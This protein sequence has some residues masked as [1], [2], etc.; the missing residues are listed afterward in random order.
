MVAGLISEPVLLHRFIAEIHREPFGP[1][2]MRKPIADYL[3]G[4]QRLGRLG[5]FPIDAALTLM[6]GPTLVLGFT[7]LVGG[8]PR[9][10]VVAA[11]PDIIRTL[12]SGIAPKAEGSRRARR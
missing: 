11:I 10:A 6:I 9:H 5:E 4:E 3:S 12:L 2:Q 7:E 8:A 1:E